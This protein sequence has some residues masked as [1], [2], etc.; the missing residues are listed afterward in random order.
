MTAAWSKGCRQHYPYYLCDTRDCPSKRKSIPRAKIEEGFAEIP[1]SME[2]TR[3]L[4]DV[5][6]AMLCDAWDLR[7]NEGHKA[8]EEWG[9]QLKETAKQI[10]GLLDRIVD[11]SNPSVITAYEQ[12]IAKLERQKIILGEKAAQTVPPKGRLEEVIELSMKFLSSPWQI[13]QNGSR[14]VQQT[15]LRLAFAEPLRYSRN[16]GYRTPGTNPFRSGC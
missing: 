5:A 9:R 16:E 12:R 14:A 13:Y 2:P 3:Q 1:K 6:R 11:A 8:K 7:L 10:E 4:F 15:V